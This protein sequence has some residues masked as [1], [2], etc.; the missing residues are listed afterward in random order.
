M[1]GADTF[2]NIFKVPELKKRILFTLGILAVYRIGAHIP[3]PGIDGVA[4]AEI[5]EQAKGTILGFFDMFSGGALSRLTIFA[6]GI[7][8]YISA[9]IILQLLTI[10]SPHLARLKKEGEQGQKKITQYTRYGTIVLS[11][12][13]SS[14]ISVGLEA[15]K[16]PGG[17]AIV[18]EPGWGFRLMTILT[19][20]A[21]TAFIMWLGEQ[22]TER[23]VGNG[24]SLIIFAGIVAGTP[25]AIFQSMDLMGTGELSV[26][27]V[28]ALLLLMMTVVAVIVF[29]EGG[30]RRIPIQY[31]KRMVGRKMHG[32]TST[33]LPLKVNT[34]GVI[35]PIFASSI[36]MFPA[37]MA[38]FIDAPIM[39]TVSA[40]LT[41]GNVIYSLIFIGAIFFFCYFY[42]AVIFNPTEVSDNMKKH[43]GYVPG[44]R[45]GVKTSEY[46]DK[47]LT[48]LTF[49]GAIYLS[50]ICILPDYLIKYINIPFYFGG[51]SL[52]I[53]VGVSL[54]TMQQIESHLVMRNY[55]GFVKKGKLRSRRG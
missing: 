53:V 18:P 31:A 32:G 20:T 16:S 51:T 52:L 10:V 28:F 24:I 3:T 6:L 19:L 12:I 55:D 37:T 13:Q 27:I 43:G 48:K 15:M 14:G 17:A 30:Q 5:F 47:I 34:S 9:S 40:A 26:F 29:T 8:P 54:D 46:I 33:H 44:I 49:F 50:F 4:L 1:S 7:M 36:I 11:M 35:P 41:P 2:G 22:I 45:P 39:Q 23:G 21:G 25:S 38:Q 42:T